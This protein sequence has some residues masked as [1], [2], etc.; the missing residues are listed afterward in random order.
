MTVFTRVRNLSLSWA[1]WIQSMPS[2]PTSW[3]STLIFFS[4]L[5]L[6]LPSILFSP[7]FPTKTLYTPLPSPIHATCPSHLILLDLVTRIIFGETYRSLGSSLCS[8]PHSPVNSSLLG[9]NIFFSTLFSL[10]VCDQVSHPHITTG[11]IIFLYVLIFI[12]LDSKLEDKRC[13]TKWQQAFSD[14]SMLLISS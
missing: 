14:F 6:G 1:R 10:R 8:F 3:R 11:K 9:P 7:D 2:H 5:H 13:C 4:Y 12:L